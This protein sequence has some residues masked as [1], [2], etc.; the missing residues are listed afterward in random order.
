[1]PFETQASL[2]P[3]AFVDRIIGHSQ[4][5]SALKPAKACGF[6]AAPVNIALSKYWGKRE[7]TLNLPI[8]GSVSISL[9][10]LGT[11]TDLSLTEGQQDQIVLNDQLLEPHHPFA[12]RLSGFL[13]Y[14]RPNDHTMFHVDTLNSVPTAAGLASSAS[15]YAALVLALNDLFQWQLQPKKLSL[16]ARLGSGSAS[17]SLYPGFAIW[18]KGERDDGMDSYAEAIETSWPELCIGLLKIDIGEKSV[19]STAGMQQTVNTCELYQ[20][21]PQQAEKDVLKIQQAITDK[22]FTLLG[23]TA[24]H[25]ALSMHATMIAT[26]PPILYWQPESV[27]AMHTIWQLRQ[28]GVTV[29]FTMDAGPNLKLLFLETQ[30]PAIEQAFAELEVIQPFKEPLIESEVP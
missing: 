27:A 3:Q 7:T 4:Q 16:L 20:T 26:W 25:N 15:G 21:W 19:G 1:M 14:F 9:P 23:E 10:G 28:Q 11:Q 6:G 13:D 24:E 22:D 2:S 17:R 5:D 29:Y 8:N 30:K 12:K 18:H